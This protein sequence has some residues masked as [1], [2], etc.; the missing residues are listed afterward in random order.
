MS[1]TVI[2]AKY[3]KK[4]LLVTQI[5]NFVKQYSNLMYYYIHKLIYFSI[6]KWWFTVNFI[7]VP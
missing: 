3:M 2:S 7:Y 6:L 5:V 4:T 1:F